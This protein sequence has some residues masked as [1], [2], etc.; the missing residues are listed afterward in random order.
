M[1]TIEDQKKADFNKWVDTAEIQLTDFINMNKS[2]GQ[3]ALRHSIQKLAKTSNIFDESFKWWK[4][5]VNSDEL[6]KAE[7]LCKR[8]VSLHTKLELEYNRKD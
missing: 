1:P 8:I 2:N 5:T 3:N 7:K 4:N 6:H